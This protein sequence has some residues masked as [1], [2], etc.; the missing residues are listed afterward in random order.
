MRRW[1]PVRALALAATLAPC[2]LIAGRSPGSALADGPTSPLRVPV[3]HYRSPA[4]TAQGEAQ[5]HTLYGDDAVRDV[6]LT[7]ASDNWL[8]LMGCDRTQGMGGPGGGASAIPRIDVPA[9]MVVDGVVIGRVGVHCKGNSTLNASGSKKPLNIA[10]DAFVPG[11]TAFGF[12]VIN[13]NNNWNDPSQLREALALRML[14]QY[15]PISRFAFA[16]LRV[17]GKVI[18]LYSMVEQI[19]SEWAAHWYDEDDGMIVKGDS[20]IQ[21]A[22]DSS[23]LTWK[24][25]ALAPYKSGYEVKGKA[26]DGDAGYEELREMIRALSAPTAEG[27]IGDAQFESKI[28]DVLDV[29]SALWYL[30]GNNV[31]ANFDSY[32]VGKNYYLY[33]GKRDARWDVIPWDLGLSFGLFGLRAGG[34]GGGGRPGGGGGAT[35]TALADPFAQST[36]ATRPLIRRLLAVPSFKADYVA[37]YRALMDDVFKPAWLTEVGQSYQ[38]IVHQAAADEVAAQGNISGAFTLAQFEANLLYDVTRGTGGGF[39]GGAAPGIVALA[40]ARQEYLNGLP[41]LAAPDLHLSASSHAPDAPTSADAVTIRADFDGADAPDAVE[42]RY[43]VHGG[44]EQRAAMMRGEDG[45]WTATIPAQRAG[46]TV[47]YALRAGTADGRSKF[48]PAANQTEPYRYDVAGVE[49]PHANTGALV[50]NEVLSSN[51][52]TNTDPAGEYEDWVELYN[53]GDAPIDL[54]GYFLSDDPY[55]PFRFSLPSRSLGPGEYALVW[56]DADSIQGDDHA[57]FRISK[58]GETIVLSNGDAIVDEIATGAIPPDVSLGRATDGADAW[59]LCARPTPLQANACN[60]AMAVPARAY[61]PW[62]GR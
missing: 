46:R 3:R 24:G 39:G 35:S 47:T 52:S 38:D 58:D 44:I 50:L 37:H 28:N 43:R 12:D 48:F 40:T 13:L 10:T 29:D 55:D 57:P 5:A 62:G 53:R 22:F 6:E 54:G 33:R 8:G 2:L 7:F 26:Q 17:Q 15:M 31:I 41:A 61:L 1:S 16:R 36:D 14:G 60:G 34:A 56:C 18:G 23:P 11:Q 25:E 27:G 42:V 20:P 21:I 32:Y 19:N 45:T 9:D 49:L 59:D 30:A 4:D 51:T